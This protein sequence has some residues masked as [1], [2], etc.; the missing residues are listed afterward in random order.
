MVDVFF[1]HASGF[2]YVEHQV[3]FSAVETVSAKQNYESMCIGY[4]NVF[5][6]Y[7]NDNG[8]FKG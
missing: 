4:V 1:D 5:N 7:L 2:L 3:W 6:N 8:V